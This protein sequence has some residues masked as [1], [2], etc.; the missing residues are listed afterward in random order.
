[1]DR[2]GA[3]GHSYNPGTLVERWEAEAGQSPNAHRPA[4]L[5]D[6]QHQ[7]RDAILNKGKV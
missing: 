5:V 6:L 1:M 2:G 7:T 3:G 4:S